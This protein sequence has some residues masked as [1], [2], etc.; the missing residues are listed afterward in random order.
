MCALPSPLCIPMRQILTR[1]AAKSAIEVLLLS[2]SLLTAEGKLVAKAP[3]VKLIYNLLQNI[4]LGTNTY[5]YVH[6]YI[7]RQPG[8]EAAASGLGPSFLDSQLGVTSGEG[9]AS[10]S[11]RGDV[12]HPFDPKRMPLTSRLCGDV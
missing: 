5:T 12:L 3:S 11:S 10:G 1:V 6:T 4:H 9:P 7:H 8:T 2:Y